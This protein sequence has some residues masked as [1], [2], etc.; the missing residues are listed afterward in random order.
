MR[1]GMAMLACTVKLVVMQFMVV[2]VLQKM[3]LVNSSLLQ[4]IIHM[5]YSRSKT[6]RFGIGLAFN[7]T[8][9]PCQCQISTDALQLQNPKTKRVLTWGNK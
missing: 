3:G 4:V 9:T 6:Q 2:A 5:I 1:D 8:T 7:L